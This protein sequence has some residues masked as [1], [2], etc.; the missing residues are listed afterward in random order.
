[1]TPLHCSALFNP[2]PL[3][4]CA[5]FRLFFL[6]A[7]FFCSLSPRTAISQDG[8]LTTNAFMAEYNQDRFE[9]EIQAK[10]TQPPERTTTAKVY[11]SFSSLLCNCWLHQSHKDAASRKVISEWEQRRGLFVGCTALPFLVGKDYKSRE[12]QRHKRMRSFQA[13]NQNQSLKRFC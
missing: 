12:I 9:L 3:F 10:E 13:E 1:M 11:V 8:R 4:H 7:N 6:N 5:N 2:F